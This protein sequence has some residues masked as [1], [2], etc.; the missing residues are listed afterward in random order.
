L[1][2]RYDLAVSWGASVPRSSPKTLRE[3]NKACADLDLV[4]RD[5]FLLLETPGL[6]RFARESLV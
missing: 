3:Q 2:R 5:D 1:H 4:G 6:T